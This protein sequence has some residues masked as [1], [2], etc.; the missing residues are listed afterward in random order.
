MKAI[1]ILILCHIGGLIGALLFCLF[2]GYE[3]R[4]T[5]PNAEGY[6]WENQ[7]LS[8]SVI[9]KIKRDTTIIRFID[10]SKHKYKF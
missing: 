6:K 9:G 1:K 4:K 10:G 2:F 3:L 7:R 8:N 5:E